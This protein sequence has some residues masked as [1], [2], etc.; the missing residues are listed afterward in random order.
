MN[1]TSEE[2][3]SLEY[4]EFSTWK[5]FPEFYKN[6]LVHQASVTNPKYLK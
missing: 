3:E 1:R 6:N 4:Y 2:I 5:L